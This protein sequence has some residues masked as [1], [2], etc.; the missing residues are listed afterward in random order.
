MNFCAFGL[1][2]AKK[3]S[4]LFNISIGENDGRFK[5]LDAVDALMEQHEHEDPPNKVCALLADMP[6][7]FSSRRSARRLHFV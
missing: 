1:K 5:P 6:N 3:T 2:R 4:L 7:L